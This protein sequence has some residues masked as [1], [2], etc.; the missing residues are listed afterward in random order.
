MIFVAGGQR[1]H[2]WKNPYTG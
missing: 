2:W 1:F